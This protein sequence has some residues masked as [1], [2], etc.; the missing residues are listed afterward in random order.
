MT[1]FGW[2]LICAGS[3]KILYDLLLLMQFRAQRPDDELPAPT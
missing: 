2:P 1:S 3:L